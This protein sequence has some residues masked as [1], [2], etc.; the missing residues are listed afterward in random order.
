M[1]A[2]EEMVNSFEK[3]NVDCDTSITEKVDGKRSIFYVVW[4]VGDCVVLFRCF[5]L[6]VRGG[7]VE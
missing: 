7:V 1:L 5:E 3:P 4:H 2:L 6:L